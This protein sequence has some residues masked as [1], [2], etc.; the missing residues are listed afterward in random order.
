VVAT[1]LCILLAAPMGYYMARASPRWRQL[2]L[3]LVIVP[4]WTSFL[5]RIFAWKV[6]LHPE[7]PLKQAL[8]FLR[9]GRPE[10]SLLYNEGAVLLVMVYTY[11][12]FAILPIYA[13]AEKFDFR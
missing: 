3:L 1:A 10:A 13:A 9:A 8:V 12:P 11:L 7:G 6:L 2:V 4:F 5:V